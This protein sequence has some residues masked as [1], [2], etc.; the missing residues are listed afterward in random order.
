[1]DLLAGD[2]VMHELIDA[3]CVERVL[4]VGVEEV[5]LEHQRLVRHVAL[6]GSFAGE[7]RG[8]LHSL[9][10][11]LAVWLAYA[12]PRALE[13][14]GELLVPLLLDCFSFLSRKQPR[15]RRLPK[16]PVVP[17]HQL[18][19]AAVT[20]ARE[21]RRKVSEQPC[22]KQRW[23][24]AHRRHPPL[25]YTGKHA[26]FEREEVLE[27]R[28]GHAVLHQ[29]DVGQGGV[30][31]LLAVCLFEALKQADNEVTNSGVDGGRLVLVLLA[32]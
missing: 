26:V 22:D 8:P 2:E 29:C 20:P 7:E 13:V 4:G 31:Q 28:L 12:S 11:L 30:H 21:E 3:A 17:R 19:A 5:A 10:Q 1:M 27:L 15:F 16:L 25:I 32:E 14:V 6:G 24:N 23:R 9:F 18:G